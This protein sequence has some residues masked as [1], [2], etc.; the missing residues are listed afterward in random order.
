MN[1]QDLD[2]KNF[3][4]LD[5]TQIMYPIQKM[6]QFVILGLINS[7]LVNFYYS[8]KFQDSHMKG[9]YFRCYTNYLE[10]IPIHKGMADQD[11]KDYSKEKHDLISL[12]EKIHLLKERL[13]KM[14]YKKT[15]ERSSIE[16]ELKETD[17]K[18]DEFVYALYNITDEER[19]LIESSTK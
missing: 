15:D 18:I 14:G 16:N 1:Y 10:K 7:K 13:Q 6:N 2:M 19:K 3:Y 11:P 9:G 17:D 5:T 4:T 8:T 12:T